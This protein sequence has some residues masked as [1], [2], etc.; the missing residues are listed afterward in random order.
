M[1]NQWTNTNWVAQE[2]LRLL[3]NK[4]EIASFFATKWNDEFKKDFAVGE[5][6]TI[7]KPQRYVIRDGMNYSAQALGPQT[8]TITL[9]QVF[10]IDF[11]WDDYEAAIKMERSQ[12]E[13]RRMY[14]E[15]AAN[16]MKQELESR[17]ALFAYRNTPNVFG[18]LAS[19]PTAA[20]PF[21]DAEARLFEKSCPDGDKGLF[22]TSRMLSSFLAN[23]AV[24]FN[25]SSEIAKQ[26][27][28][29]L[30]G[31]AHGWEWHRSNSLYRH[32]AGTAVT[33]L[34][35][36]GAGQSGSSILL[37][38]T[39]GEILRKGDVV[40]IANVNFVNPNTLRVP[41]G[42][43]VQH[44]V[45][46]GEDQTA[47][48]SEITATLY[49][50]IVGPG[51]PYQNV[52]ALPANAAAVTLFPGTG[53]PSGKAGAQGLGLAK[54]MAFALV[55]AKFKMPQNVEPGSTMSSPD[56]DTGLSV[57]F[58][59]QWDINTSKLKNR[60]DMCVG[61]GVLYADECAVRIVGA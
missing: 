57:R 1:P 37:N 28:S 21:L 3:T 8:T 46:I 23:Q 15:P 35:I 16:K 49:P 18:A 29:G 59:R 19:N 34:T 47:A 32:T 20:T 22:I 39:N 45:H 5:T 53:T 10:G 51:S 11:E 33:G 48:G 2:I 24:Q 13:V 12:A 41:A 61:F 25:P 36:K 50:S 14:L 55:G 40:S 56:P 60:Y 9:N 52:D 31:T 17:C 43:Q 38:A 7:K 54:G 6:V 26:Y 30:V 44:F 4:L 58:T 42:N 27:K